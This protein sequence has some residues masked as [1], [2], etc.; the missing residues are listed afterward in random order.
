ML[1]PLDWRLAPSLLGLVNASPAART[2]ALPNNVCMDI[3]A[4]RA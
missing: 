1:P 3:K 2:S 4:V